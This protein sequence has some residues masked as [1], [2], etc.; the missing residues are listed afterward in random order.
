MSF[1]M[2]QKPEKVNVDDVLDLEWRSLSCMNHSRYMISNTGLLKTIDTGYTTSGSKRHT[3]YYVSS[4]I[5]DN[6]ISHNPEIHR[7]VAFAFLGIPDDPTL[8]V[9][10]IDRNRSNNNLNNL[11][12]ATKSQQ[13]KNR[14]SRTASLKCVGKPVT[15]MTLNGVEIMTWFMGSYAERY[16]ESTGV[17][18]SHISN[19]CIKGCQDGGYLWKYAR[20]DIPGEEW[21]QVHDEDFKLTVWASNKGRIK[22]SDGR[23][24]FGYKQGKHKAISIAHKNQKSHAVHRLVLLAFVGP[25][26]RVVNHKDAN[27][28]NNKLENLEYVTQAQNV[29]H[30]H[31]NGLISAPKNG[32]KQ[33]SKPLIQIDMTGNIVGKYPSSV[34]AAKIT[35]FHVTSI[36]KACREAAIFKGFKWVRIAKE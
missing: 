18:C 21:A 22:L 16:I 5:D 12:W 34:E 2:L 17:K 13:N 14:I 26:D 15:Q 11:R 19:A 6:G 36:N 9:D 31:D 24:S 7:L 30:A 10:H 35:G 29:Q 1:E 8:T 4:I 25:D 23:I 28:F 20:E 32:N 33:R 3:G 27:G